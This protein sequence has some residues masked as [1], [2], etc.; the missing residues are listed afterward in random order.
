MAEETERKP[1]STAPSPG[2]ALA[3][4]SPASTGSVLL[5]YNRLLGGRLYLHTW[6]RLFVA[7]TIVVGALFAKYLVGISELKVPWLIALGVIIAAYNSAAWFLTRPYRSPERAGD[8][9]EFLLWIMYVAIVLD[10]LSLGAAVWLVGGARSPFVAFYLLHIFLSGIMLSRRAAIVLTILAYL[11]LVVLVVGELYGVLP[12]HLPEGAI[13]SADPLDGRYALTLLVVYA[14]LFGLAT[15]LLVGLS[16]L[17]RRGEHELREVNVELSRLSSLRR[18]F[19]H[20]TLHDLKSPVG[21]ITSLMQNLGD[22]LCGELNERQADWVNRSIQRLNGLSALLQDLHSLASLETGSLDSE[23]VNFDVGR[24]LEQVVQ[25]HQDLAGLRGHTLTLELADKLPPVWGV[26]QLMKQAVGN[27]ITN[28]VKYTPEGG[29]ITV[30][31]RKLDGVVRIEVEDSGVGI[32][33]EDQKRLFNEFVRVKRSTKL[34][35]ASGTGLGLSIVKRIVDRHNGRA[36]VESEIDKGSTFV[37]EL[38]A[39]GY[40]RRRPLIRPRTFIRTGS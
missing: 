20:I 12:P 37:I 17:L 22:G 1:G 36:F 9:Y 33:A 27:F 8:A 11:M 3:P 26:E 32:S 5:T 40:S 39:S 18:D 35:R 34:T 16:S 24:T 6:I 10:F 29:R 28:A 31:G 38:P 13:P 30:R 14:M 4:A 15:F 19:L 23:A 7:F 2:S 21:A 25:E